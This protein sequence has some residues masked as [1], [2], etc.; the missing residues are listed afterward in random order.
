MN[1]NPVWVLLGVHPAVGAW[2]PGWQEGS[3]HTGKRLHHAP[4]IIN[5]YGNENCFCLFERFI[6]CL[7]QAQPNIQR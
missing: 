5:H 2:E 6:L 1:I 7:S 4:S 3:E